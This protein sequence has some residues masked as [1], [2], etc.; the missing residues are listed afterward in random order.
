MTI[1]ERVKSFIQSKKVDKKDQ[2]IGVEIEYIIYNKNFLRLPVNPCNHFSAN[3]FLNHMNVGSKMNGGYTLEPGGQLEWSSPPFRNLID[4]NISFEKHNK[5][6]K[7]KIDAYDLHVLDLSLDPKYFPD[8]IDLIEKPKYQ[9]MDSNMKKSGTMGQWMMRNTASVQINYDITGSKDL[10]EMVFIADCLNPVAAYMFSNSPFKGGKKVGSKNYRN[11]IWENTDVKRCCNLINHGIVSE[12]ELIDNFIDFVLKVPGIFQLNRK[13]MVE[14][15]NNS[16]GERLTY[17]ESNDMLRDIDIQT[18]LH[19][20]F[21]N[22]RLKNLIEVRGSDKPPFGYEMAPVAF[23]TGLLTVPEIRK[24]LLDTVSNWSL[25]E[26]TAWNKKSL[27]L[28][29]KQKGPEGK[30]YDYWNKWA[31]EMALKG[32]KIRDYHESRFFDNFF[33]I[34]LE[35]GPFS[36]QR[37]SSLNHSLFKLENF[38]TK[39]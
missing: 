22:V 7:E 16:L 28:N 36:I 1:N 3:D 13:E 37:Q 30:S 38:F 14:H 20:I 29:Q 26:R 23:W 31:G 2:R 17:L 39:F 32:L 6:L 5:L 35:K 10:E 12:N 18:A 21:T 25:N 19:Q 33:E 34:I 9:M 8:D 27:T 24:V 4:L 11:Y 15:S